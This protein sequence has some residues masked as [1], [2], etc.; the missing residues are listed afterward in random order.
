[1]T[2][3]RWLLNLRATGDRRGWCLGCWGL[4]LLVAVGVVVWV[5]VASRAP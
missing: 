1:M 2:R 3:P 4:H 5:A